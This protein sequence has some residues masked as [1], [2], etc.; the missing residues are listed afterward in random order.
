M[1]LGVFDLLD[2]ATVPQQLS[3]RRFAFRIR[4]AAQIVTVEHEK[5]E[6]SF[7]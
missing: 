7:E 5:I 6:R 1:A 2:T 4:L 3:Q